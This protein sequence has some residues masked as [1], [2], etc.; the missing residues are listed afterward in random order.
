MM[1]ESRLR[2]AGFTGLLLT[3]LLS[4]NW[5][6]AIE[7]RVSF[8]KETRSQPFTG[9]VVLLFSRARTQP[10]M[11]PSW[12]RPETIVSQDVENWQPG[13]TISFN[14]KNAK[15]LLSFPK[16]YNELDVNGYYVQAVARFN[17]HHRVIGRGVGNGTTVT[18]TLPVGAGTT[19]WQANGFYTYILSSI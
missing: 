1:N 10:R 11:G 6:D 12:F 13:G 15:S 8:S 2:F 16:P 19:T 7:I 5:A 4:I 3:G 17:P 9:R 14:A 18:I